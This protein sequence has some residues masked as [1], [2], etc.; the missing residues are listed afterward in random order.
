MKLKA[1][2]ALL[3]LFGVLACSDENPKP[4]YENVQ[5]STID[6]DYDITIPQ[7]WFNEGTLYYVNVARNYLQVA[8]DYADYLPPAVPAT[9]VKSRKAIQATNA[10]TVF[11]GSKDPLVYTWTN[12]DTHTDVAY[13]ISTKGDSYLFA[14]FVKEGD[15]WLLETFA[16]EKKG[17][18]SGYMNIYYIHDAG[19][20]ESYYTYTWSQHEN[21]REMT[22]S[23]GPSSI[24]SVYNITEKN[25][26]TESRFN[27]SSELTIVHIDW[28]ADGSGT[29][30]VT[31]NGV[32]TE[33]GN[34]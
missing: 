21:I 24:H 26:A 28:E 19:E 33:S 2:I 17:T 1:S 9:A 18:S 11:S 12:E 16:M 29:Y 8:N 10:G 14:T 32:Q 7:V 3:L 27:G 25:G 20:E 30:Y 4:N 15:A 6:A 31:R 13:Q 5:L 34:L 22:Y 23:D